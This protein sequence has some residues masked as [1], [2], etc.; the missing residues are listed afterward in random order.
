MALPLLPEATAP[1]AE[2]VAALVL[3]V[4]QERRADPTVVSG[5]GQKGGGGEGGGGR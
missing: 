2:D 1:S 5:P 4:E 3:Q